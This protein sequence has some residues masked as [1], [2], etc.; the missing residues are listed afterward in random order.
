MW[1]HKLEEGHVSHYKLPGNSNAEATSNNSQLEQ[2]GYLRFLR[3]I[4][5]LRLIQIIIGYQTLFSIIDSGAI[6][7]TTVSRLVICFSHLNF[8]N[9]ILL[10]G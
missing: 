10:G 5:N 3:F 7:K 2:A 6:S 4:F 9:I 8:D 1:E